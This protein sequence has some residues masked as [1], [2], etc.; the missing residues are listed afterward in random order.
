MVYELERVIIMAFFAKKNKRS[1]LHDIHA[2]TLMTD[3]VSLSEAIS[4]LRLM[5]L[6]YLLPPLHLDP[7]SG[8]TRVFK[9]EDGFVCGVSPGRSVCCSCPV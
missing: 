7:E 6:F 2:C 8:L 1:F 9:G 5:L 3:E 4:R